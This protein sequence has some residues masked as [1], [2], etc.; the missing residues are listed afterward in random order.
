MGVQYLA[1]LGSSWAGTSDL[2]NSY[3]ALV[4]LLI[5]AWINYLGMLLQ[6]AFKFLSIHSLS[7][8]N[9]WSWSCCSSKLRQLCLTQ[10]QQHSTG[11]KMEEF[12]GSLRIM[13]PILFSMISVSVW[14][15]GCLSR[16]STTPCKLRCSLRFVKNSLTS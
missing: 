2:A 1:S 11:L 6:M 5:K 7:M 15:A 3:M 16:T 4:V 12:T 10:A 9:I 8:F 13:Q 14:C